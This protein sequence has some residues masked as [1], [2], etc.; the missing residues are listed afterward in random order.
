[1]DHP[2]WHESLFILGNELVIAFLPKNGNFA[3]FLK[4]FHQNKQRH[5]SPSFSPLPHFSL[6][7][8]P[9][10]SLFYFI[11]CSELLSISDRIE[12]EFFRKIFFP[13]FL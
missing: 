1:V 13:I 9:L 3:D 11:D 7:S 5:P 6:S 2:K 12:R 4:F 8:F 10:L